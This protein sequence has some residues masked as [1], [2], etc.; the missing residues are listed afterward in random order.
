MKQNHAD[1]HTE[2]QTENESKTHKDNQLETHNIRRPLTLTPYAQPE[3][4]L[5]ALFSIKESIQTHN[6][7]TRG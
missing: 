7:I 1:N 5:F 6:N 2:N 3:S 4:S